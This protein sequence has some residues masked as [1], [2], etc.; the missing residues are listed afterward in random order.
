MN[1][2]SPSVGDKTGDFHVQ[3]R[4]VDRSSALYERERSLETDWE[5]PFTGAGCVR[6]SIASAVADWGGVASEPALTTAR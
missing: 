2:T 4:K 3:L 1:N 6:C 5:E